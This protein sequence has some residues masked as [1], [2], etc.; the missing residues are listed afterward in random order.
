[1]STRWNLQVGV[2][3]NRASE[4]GDSNE[5]YFAN[6]KRTYSQQFK[7]N[8]F[9]LGNRIT[10]PT[11]DITFTWALGFNNAYDNV[12]ESFTKQGVPGE[13][14]EIEAFSTS[15]I[16]T[17]TG[18]I[19]IEYRKVI[20]FGIS[21]NYL[22]E[23]GYRDVTTFIRTPPFVVGIDSDT[24][25]ELEGSFLNFGGML[26]TGAVRLIASL[27]TPFTLKITDLRWREDLNNSPVPPS[28]L[29]VLPTHAEVKVPSVLTLGANIQFFDEGIRLFFEYQKRDFPGFKLIYL[30]PP[31]GTNIFGTLPKG[32]AIRLGSEFRLSKTGFIRHLRIGTFDESQSFRNVDEDKPVSMKGMSFGVEL[33]FH[34][35]VTVDMA[36]DRASWTRKFEY[37]T[38]DKSMSTVRAT[39]TVIF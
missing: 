15:G 32:R 21:Y 14:T 1:M 10:F 29:P 38:I 39:A 28:E 31:P 22:I 12:S 5:P 33:A 34:P 19:G 37:L 36:F 9:S 20:S 23:S 25:G 7:V 24:R 6:Y 4:Q 2:R 30:L 13:E 35:H 26:R 18:G 3:L 27:Q 17:L 16:N 11:N 8:N